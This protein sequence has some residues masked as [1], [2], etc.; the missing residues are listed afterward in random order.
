[1]MTDDP[2]VTIERHGTGADQWFTI[3]YSDTTAARGGRIIVTAHGKTI[4]ARLD[5]AYPQADIT[6]KGPNGLTIR[7]G[8]QHG[9]ADVRSLDLYRVVLEWDPLLVETG[10][11]PNLRETQL[12]TNRPLHPREMEVIRA[13]R[14]TITLLDKNYGGSPLYS[15]VPELG[16]STGITVLLR[17]LGARNVPRG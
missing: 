17:L 7:G 11:G 5:A 3:H 6:A 13:E 10:P 2:D 16:A 15:L 9:W 4:R 12:R 1:M 14:V 8:T